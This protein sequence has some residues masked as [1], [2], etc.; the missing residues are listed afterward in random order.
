[1]FHCLLDLVDCVMGWR[2]EYILGKVIVWAC[3]HEMYAHGWAMPCT[4]SMVGVLGVRPYCHACF[5]QAAN[6]TFP[7]AVTASA[8]AV[9]AAAEAATEAAVAQVATASESAPEKH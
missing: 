2:S 4:K 6:L 7:P 3:A 8:M 1:M 9:V 5:L